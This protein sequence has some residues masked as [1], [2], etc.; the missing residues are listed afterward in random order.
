MFCLSLF[1]FSSLAQRD[2]DRGLALWA[3]AAARA[4]DDGSEEAAYA[5]YDERSALSEEQKALY[6][7]GNCLKLAADL[8]FE[9]AIT[10]LKRR[11]RN[12]EAKAIYSQSRRAQGT[13]RFVRNDK[14]RAWTQKDERGDAFL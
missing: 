13:E 2:V 14:A 4:P 5:I 6:R 8:G 1:F 9:R 12:R 10:E 3:E 7:P 11:R